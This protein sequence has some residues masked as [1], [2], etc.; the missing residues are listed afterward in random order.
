MPRIVLSRFLSF[1]LL[2]MASLPDL[3]TSQ[4][5]TKVAGK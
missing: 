2:A 3:F 1:N 5:T 4:R